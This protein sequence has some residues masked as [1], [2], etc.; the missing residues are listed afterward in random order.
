[1]QTTGNVKRVSVH[2]KE[3]DETTLM[4]P[5]DLFYPLAKYTRLFGD[6]TLPANRKRKH[7]VSKVSGVR[8]L[9]GA[10]RFSSRSVLVSSIVQFRLRPITPSMVSVAAVVLTIRISRP[11]ANAADPDWRLLP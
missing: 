3:F 2:S 8:G 1:M 4:K 5:D 6:P 9:P 11:S 7:V 10:V